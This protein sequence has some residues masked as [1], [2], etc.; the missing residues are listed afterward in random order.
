MVLLHLKID[1]LITL[2]IL[3]LFIIIGI[4]TLLPNIS[5]SLY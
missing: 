1:W 4:P 5:K 3:S 2:T